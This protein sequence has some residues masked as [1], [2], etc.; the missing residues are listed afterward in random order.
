[1][2]GGEGA[3]AASTALPSAEGRRGNLKTQALTGSRVCRGTGNQLPCS[4]PDRHTD[5]SA[6]VPYFGKWAP[7]AKAA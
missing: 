2:E 7:G 6:F 1:M 4:S 3:Y 5:S